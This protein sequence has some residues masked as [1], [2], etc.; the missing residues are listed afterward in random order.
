MN[1]IWIRSLVPALGTGWCTTVRDG[2]QV[3]IVERRSHIGEMRWFVYAKPYDCDSWGNTYTL[4]GIGSLTLAQQFVENDF[5]LP[6]ERVPVETL[7]IVVTLLG[8]GA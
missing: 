2:R 7:A 1:L 4:H 3:A 6:R 5:K 8:G